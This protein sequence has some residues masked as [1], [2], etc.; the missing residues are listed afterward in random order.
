[1]AYKMLFIPLGC[2]KNLVDSERML[3]ILTGYGFELTDN[4]ADADAAVINTCTFIDEAKSESIERIIE[5][6]GYKD[7]K[8]GKL[9]ALLVAGCMVER[10]RESLYD[11]IPEIDAVIGLANIPDI[12][13]V[14]L[15]VLEG[16][17]KLMLGDIPMVRVGKPKNFLS[18]E[19]YIEPQSDTSAPRISL[20]PPFWSYLKVADGCDNPCSFCVIPAIR[21]KFKSVPMDFLV[22]RAKRLAADGVREINLIAQDTSNYG[23]DL[24]G[25]PRLSELIERISKIEDIKW[26]RILYTYP[27][28]VNDKLID[29]I[30][31]NPKVCKYIDVPL[32]HVADSVLKHMKRGMDY[33]KTAAFVK[34]LRDRIPEICIRTSFI[35]G[36]PGETADDLN[37]LCNFI[38]E[39]KLDKVGFFRYSQEEGTPSADCENQVEESVKQKRL[40]KVS[41]AYDKVL[42]ESNESLIG[43]TLEFLIEDY[44]EEKELLI[45]RSYREA[46]EVDGY[47]YISAENARY[48]VP[49]TFLKA[50]V[51]K[52]KKFELY[53]E[54]IE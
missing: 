1:M 3:E 15:W 21:G 30:A 39:Y 28:H 26:I 54:A 13:S 11:E 25:E 27:L 12:A 29:V 36:Y 9:R 49:G 20:T 6:A 38:T 19:N 18:I 16:N 43:R 8:K 23:R 32:Q 53:A 22:A 4:P 52:A 47:I 51:K 37:S 41:R 42:K 45:A 10:Y 7:P 34:K 31:D 40:K 14:A 35:I 50:S 48:I 24:Y 33:K 46:P 2:A 5:T 17:K 44:D